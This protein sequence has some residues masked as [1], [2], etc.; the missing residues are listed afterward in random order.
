MSNT[1][2]KKTK[3]DA[4]AQVRALIAGTQKH[5]PNGTFTLGNA[6]YTAATLIQGLT[7]LENAL[8]ALNGA[9]VQLKEAVQTADGIE[10]KVAPVIRDYKRF[11]LATFST[12]PQALA[13]FGVQAP[14]AH[15]PLNSDQRAVAT[16]KLRAT[17]KARGTT[18]KKQKDRFQSW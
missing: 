11:I 9:H 4:L 17:R 2:S 12:A 18:S 7:D 13:D 10:T 1:T 15:T 14:K 16:A 5:Y 3:T 8:V 6:S